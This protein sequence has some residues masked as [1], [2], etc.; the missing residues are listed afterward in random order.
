[1]SQ[2]FLAGLLP[3]R[4][5]ILVDLLAC[6]LEGLPDLPDEHHRNRLGA[7][8]KQRVHPAKNLDSLDQ[9]RCRPCRLGCAR[10]TNRVV[11]IGL[12]AVRDQTDQGPVLRRGDLEGARTPVHRESPD[13]CL[14]HR[15][16]AVPV[17]T[18]LC[19]QRT[20]HECS[21]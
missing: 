7:F 11:D 5:G 10:G 20:R 6:F 13:E 1:M 16:D 17:E 9:R 4:G 18:R 14:R 15:T 8:G 21:R 2:D 12:V 3:G 19:G